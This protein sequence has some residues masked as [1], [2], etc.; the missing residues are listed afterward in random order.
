MRLT[1]PAMEHR[2]ERKRSRNRM[3]I[4]CDLD[5]ELVR[6]EMDRAAFGE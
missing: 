5:R 2:H 4:V 6:I 1:A 3:Q